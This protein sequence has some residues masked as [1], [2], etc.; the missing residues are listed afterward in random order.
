[1]EITKWTSLIFLPFLL[2]TIV[3][4]APADDCF[5][6]PSWGSLMGSM[7]C[8]TTLTAYPNEGMLR[9]IRVPVTGDQSLRWLY[10][11]MMMLSAGT[12]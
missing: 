3:F 7:P 2:L 10:A 4:G 8:L 12:R 1:M 11:M 9:I 6:V 5:S